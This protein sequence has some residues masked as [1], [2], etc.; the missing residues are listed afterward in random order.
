MLYHYNY[1]YSFKIVEFFFRFFFFFLFVFVSFVVID[2]NSEHNDKNI[3]KVYICMC[4]YI[5]L[6]DEWLNVWN[7]I[8]ELQT[9][10]ELV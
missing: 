1:Q 10:V 9:L 4:I 3:E 5:E 8:R 2:K 6:V 7:F